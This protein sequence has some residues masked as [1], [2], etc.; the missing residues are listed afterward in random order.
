VLQWGQDLPS[1]N[2]G[3]ENMGMLSAARLRL[4]GA[5][6]LFFKVAAFLVDFRR[7]GN[8]DATGF[9]TSVEVM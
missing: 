6:E 7:N 2:I 5:C 4:L 8:E 9:V 1:A 3:F